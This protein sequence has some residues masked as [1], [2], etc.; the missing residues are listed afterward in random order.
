MRT[1]HHQAAAARRTSLLAI[2]SKQP[3]THTSLHPTSDEKP[4]SNKLERGPGRSLAPPLTAGFSAHF[5]V[6]LVCWLTGAVTEIAPSLLLSSL[7]GLTVFCLAL[8][9]SKSGR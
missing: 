4:A 3:T 8:A 9:F 7:V 1:L 6:L 2:G 5:I